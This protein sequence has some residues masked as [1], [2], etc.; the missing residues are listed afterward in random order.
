MPVVVISLLL[1]SGK[2]ETKP[3]ITHFFVRQAP[4]VNFRCLRVG[5]LMPQEANFGRLH[6]DY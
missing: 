4:C 1:L 3:V 5:I 6:P 2:H